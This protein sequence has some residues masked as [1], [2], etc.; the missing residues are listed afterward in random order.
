M[1]LSLMITERLL[2]LRMMHS[3]AAISLLLAKN[4]DHTSL[5]QFVN[6]LM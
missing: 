4:L 3:Q 2:M 5:L 6:L 1:R